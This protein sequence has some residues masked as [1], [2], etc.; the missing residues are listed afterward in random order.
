MKRILLMIMAILLLS[1]CN[2]A[3]LDL[4]KVSSDLDGL[5]F[6]GNL[7]FKGE[8]VEISYLEDKYGFDSS[9]IEEYAINISASTT[10]ASMYA[11]FLPKKGEK[12]EAKAAIED[13]LEKYDQSWM[14][15]Y[16]PDQEI[17]VQNRLEDEYS[18]YL[19]YIISNDNDLAL[20]T[21]TKSE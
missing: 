11:I 5:T 21:I 18:D 6:E 20:E 12:N 9:N 3:K 17:L 10:T 13:F 2:N 7:M 8:Q 16:A 19:I 4:K 1:G 15:G 14:M